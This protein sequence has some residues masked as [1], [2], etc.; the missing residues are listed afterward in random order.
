MKVGRRAVPGRQTKNYMIACPN[1]EPHLHGLDCKSFL[2]SGQIS[3][4]S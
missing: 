2:N 3:Y 1:H 4:A